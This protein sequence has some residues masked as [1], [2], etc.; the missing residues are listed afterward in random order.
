MRKSQREEGVQ[1]PGTATTTGALGRH[2]PRFV[3]C[4]R[5]PL[6]TCCIVTPP[7]A[8]CASVNT[9]SPSGSRF[10]HAVSCACTVYFKQNAQRALLSTEPFAGV[11]RLPLRSPCTRPLSAQARILEKTHS[12]HSRRTPQQTRKKVRL[13]YQQTERSNRQ[14]RYGTT[15]RASMEDAVRRVQ[16]LGCLRRAR[17]SAQFQLKLGHRETLLPPLHRCS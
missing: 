11:G 16:G 14:H 3:V 13:L 5:P 15:R 9:P 1:E 17:T 12:G 7:T 10:T 6:Y 8:G 4:I 2:A